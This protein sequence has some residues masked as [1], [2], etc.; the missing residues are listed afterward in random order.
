MLY[1]LCTIICSSLLCNFIPTII[2]LLYS[3]Y[4]LL[5]H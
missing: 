5:E 2:I 3:Y 4:I 1:L